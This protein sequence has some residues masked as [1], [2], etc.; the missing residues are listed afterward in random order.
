MPMAYDLDGQDRFSGPSIDNFGGNRRDDVHP[1]ERLTSK[2]LGNRVSVGGLASVSHI[3]YYQSFSF[4]AAKP[5]R[6]DFL[7]YAD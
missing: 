5:S 2:I 4:A 6:L 7:G 1:T 3:Q